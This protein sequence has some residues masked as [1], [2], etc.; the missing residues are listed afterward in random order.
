MTPRGPSALLGAN[1]TPTFAF[2]AADGRVLGVQP[3][4]LPDDRAG[5]L[6]QVV[7]VGG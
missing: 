6:D 2:L 7:A 3:G 1:G 5:L 4:A